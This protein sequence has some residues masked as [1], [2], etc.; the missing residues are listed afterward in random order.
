MFAAVC[1]TWWRKTLAT[2]ADASGQSPGDDERAVYF[3]S[4]LGLD[5][6]ACQLN[7]ERFRLFRRAH[8]SGKICFIT[9]LFPICTFSRTALAAQSYVKQERWINEYDI[10][11][12]DAANAA[13][14]YC[15][16]TMIRL[17]PSSSAF[18]TLRFLLNV[19]GHR[20]AFY[21]ELER[22]TSPTG[23]V[24]AE[25]SPGYFGFRQQMLHKKHFPDAM[26]EF[27]VLFTGRCTVA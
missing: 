14:R 17:I 25:K 2:Y 13:D 4:P 11:N 9:S 3:S 18:R 6:L 5:L 19:Q 7:D 12:H 20:K 21:L 1:A 8:H 24:A 10:V 27:A 15:L 22:A 16:Y 23:R 26:D